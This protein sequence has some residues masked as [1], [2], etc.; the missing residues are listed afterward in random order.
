[1]IIDGVKQAMNPQQTTSEVTAA[2]RP[3]VFTAE[4]PVGVT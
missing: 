3:A 4:V 1:M 2:L